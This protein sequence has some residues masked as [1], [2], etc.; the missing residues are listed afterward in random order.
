[1]S[2]LKILEKTINLIV[3]SDDYQQWLKTQR[4]MFADGFHKVRLEKRLETSD[5]QRLKSNIYWKN[6]QRERRLKLKKLLA[7]ILLLISPCVLKADILGDQIK[8]SLIDHVSA[9]T[10]W[11]TKGENRLALL[12]NIVQLGQ[13]KG[14]AI[15]QLR[16]GFTGITNPAPDQVSSAGYVADA[17]INISPFIR[18]YVT[19]DP[20][21]SFLN[22]VEA[23]PAFAYDFREHHSYLAFSVGLAFGLN[24]KP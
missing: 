13:W 18:E 7:A 19:L 15:G 24:P 17:Y 6:K 16:F 4:S 1:M 5:R 3:A 9:S 21:W 23:G 22:S 14:S 12:S 10:Q 2:Y 20:S 11:T 8:T